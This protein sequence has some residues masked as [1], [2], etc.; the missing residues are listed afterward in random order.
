MTVPAFSSL[1]FTHE[2]GVRR[3][4]LS[5]DQHKAPAVTF[6]EAELMP[7][8][9]QPQ[10]GTTLNASRRVEQMEIR[11]VVMWTVFTQTDP[12]VSVDDLIEWEGR[13]LPVLGPARPGN[14]S[15]RTD[16]GEVTK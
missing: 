13:K 1:M 7:A 15:F 10:G 8:S 11:G 5:R 6:A 2:I 12:N 14:W 3:K 4:V 9:V 16:C